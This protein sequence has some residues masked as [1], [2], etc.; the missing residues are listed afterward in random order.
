MKSLI[1]LVFL[2]TFAIAQATQPRLGTRGVP[3][4]EQNVLRFRD[5]NRNGKLDPYEGWRLTPDARA[6]ATS[7]YPFGY[8]LRYGSLRA[9]SSNTP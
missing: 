3:I 8:G 5:L 6:R 7:L 4:I 1:C 2:P 9:A